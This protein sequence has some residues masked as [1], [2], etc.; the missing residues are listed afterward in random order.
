MYEKQGLPSFRSARDG[1]RE[2][3]KSGRQERRAAYPLHDW[4]WSP[5]C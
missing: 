5:D 3:A 1:R 2:K 4:K